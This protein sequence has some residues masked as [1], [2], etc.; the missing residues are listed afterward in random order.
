MSSASDSSPAS[1]PTRRVEA[2]T[3]PTGEPAT[4]APVLAVLFVGLFGTL[5]ASFPARNADLWKY[6]ADGR[7]LLRGSGEFGDSWLFGVLAYSLFWVVGGTGLAAAK[8]LLCGLVAVLMFRISISGTKGDWRV[9]LAITGLAVLA[10]G[11]RL[12]LQPATI[13]VLFLA[14]SLWLLHREEARS[15][16][17]DRSIWPGWRW[18]VLFAI[19]TNV[20]G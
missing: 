6:L 19:W 20:D 18:V 5:V 7:D 11:N 8:S 1:L 10:M 9:A 17:A 13:S 15:P 3:A 16:T 14:A 2:S 12:L 4:R